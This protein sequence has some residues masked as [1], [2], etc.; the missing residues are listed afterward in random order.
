M[1]RLACPTRRQFV[2]GALGAAAGTMVPGQADAAGMSLAVY[3]HVDAKLR[4]LQSQLSRALP[5]VDVTAYGRLGDAV[6][7]V[8]S[9]AHALLA[10]QPVLQH[11]GLSAG[12]SGVAGGKKDEPYVLMANGRQVDPSSVERVA[13]VDLLG[14]RGTQRW[15]ARLL[16]SQPQVQRVTKFEDLL[17]MLQLDMA[18]AMLIPAALVPFFRQKSRLPLQ[19]TPISARVGLPAVAVLKPGGEQIVK[20]IANLDGGLNR[21]MRVDGWV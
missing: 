10:L 13:V 15:V 11:Q 7:A 21:I 6:A 5:S 12:L 4:Y 20:Q 8:Q 2:L 17:P 1:P 3:L 14:R 18:D 19:V 9:G 16:N